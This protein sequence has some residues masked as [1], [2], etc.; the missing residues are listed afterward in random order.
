VSILTGEDRALAQ[1][2]SRLNYC[3][4]FLPE[5]I[6]LELE[7]LGQAPAQ[8]DRIWTKKVG[9]EGMHPNLKSLLLRVD[10]LV[11]RLRLQFAS[12]SDVQNDV[13]PLYQ[14]LVFFLLYHKYHGR[15]LELIEAL[16]DGKRRRVDFYDGF[17]RDMAHYLRLPRCDLMAG[18][19]PIHLFACFYQLRRAFQSIFESILGESMPAARLR[20]AV[21]QSIFTHD[22]RRYRRSLY[23]RMGDVTC[24]IVGPSGTGKDL[25]A[26]AIALSRYIPFDPAT[27]S[28]AEDYTACFLPLSLAAL[29]VTL[30]ESEL[31]G[32]LRGSFTGALT[33]RKGWLEACTPCGSVFLD[34]IGDV[35]PSVQVKLL[36]VLQS[37]VFQRIGDTK[38]RKFQ[39]KL[40][41]ATNRDLPT[42][43]GNG[44]FREDF[45]Y[46]L[47]SDRITTP[48]L[49]EQI[50]DSSGV[51][52]DLVTFLA[53]RIAGTQEA[54]SLGAEVLDW[55]GK[56]LGPRYDWPGN[57]RELEQC[58]RNIMVRMEYIPPATRS[59]GPSTLGRLVEDGALTAEELLRRYCTLVYERTGS[60]QETARRLHLDH[61]TVKKNVDP[62]LLHG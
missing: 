20:A 54:G 8:V 42:L 39:G 41:V 46:R 29:P 14:D 27:A 17:E 7:A 59:V 2:I 21:W 57:V 47:C 34:E 30:I 18:Q 55:I 49:R 19:D 31:F 10:S 5:R 60:Y 36:R 44:K 38:D 50:Q 16:A 61:R 62:D 56:H 3:N 32:H 52:D 53:G 25:V 13:A 40:I 51:L 1:A 28:F 24:L 11:E 45:Y 9:V 22:M 26:R 58:V 37:R 6:K 43:V 35:D 33:D 4:P 12:K 15:F 48:S 23:S